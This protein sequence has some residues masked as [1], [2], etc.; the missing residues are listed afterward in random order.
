MVMEQEQRQDSVNDT[1]SR[2]GRLRI[3]LGIGALCVIAGLLWWLID[4][5]EAPDTQNGT[6][7]DSHAKSHVPQEQSDQASEFATNPYLERLIGTRL[8]SADHQV[9]GSATLTG[10]DFRVTGEIRTNSSDRF[11]ILIYSNKG[12]DYLDD[13]PILRRVL[14]LVPAEPTQEKSITGE[15]I[16]HYTYSFG[17]TMQQ[18]P[19][20][21]YYIVAGEKKDEPLLVGNFTIN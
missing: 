20:L 2:P 16:R 1:T 18:I 4:L 6:P 11:V 14:D 7:V 5:P 13:A 12:E 10:T 9:T 3:F 8:P 21:Y 17:I 15:T 19:G